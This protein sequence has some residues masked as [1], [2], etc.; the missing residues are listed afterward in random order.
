L[1]ASVHFSGHVQGVGFR[2]TVLQTAKAYD[3]TGFVENLADGRV[4]L[5]A[6]GES[7]EIDDFVADVADRLSGYIRKTERTNETVPRQF[8]SF[9]IR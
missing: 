3:V 9:S 6:E 5:V 7:K 4:Y 8:K 1:R 2:Y